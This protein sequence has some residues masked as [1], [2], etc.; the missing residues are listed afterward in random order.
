MVSTRNHPKEFPEPDLSP[1]KT[2]A[3]TARK[4]KWAHTPS[5]LTLGWLAISLPLV[6][7]DTGYVLLRP[8]SMPG[9]SLHWPLWV[10]YDLYGRVDYIY[11]WKAYNARNGF[12][13]AQATMN[14]LETLSYMYYLYV[15]FAYGKASSAAGRGAPKPS[16]VGIFGQQRSVDGKIGAIAVL[17]AFSA[18]VMTV[19][20]TV[21]YCMFWLFD[22]RNAA[23]L[24]IGL[25]ESY[26]GFGNIG[27]NPILDLITLWIIPK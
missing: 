11:G 7:W 24:H 14:I 6:I 18:S 20:K 5:N 15:L 27:H 12:T 8:M 25:N 2:R 23:N 16:K 4:V 1:S 19:S 13:S 17:V 22:L 9:G 3:L 26:S 21:L 10:P